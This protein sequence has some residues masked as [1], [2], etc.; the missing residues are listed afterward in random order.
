MPK[1]AYQAGTRR[2]MAHAEREQ[3]AITGHWPPAALRLACRHDDHGEPYWAFKMAKTLHKDWRRAVERSLESKS[4]ECTTTRSGVSRRVFL[5]CVP[6]ALAGNSGCAY[7]L[8]A[9]YSE[10]HH[11]TDS[12]IVWMI[13]LETTDVKGVQHAISQTFN[14][15]CGEAV[16]SGD[17]VGAMDWRIAAH[18]LWSERRCRW[19]LSSQ[20]ALDSPSI[21]QVRLMGQ[22]WEGVDAVDD[23]ARVSDDARARFEAFTNALKGSFT[24]WASSNESMKL[25]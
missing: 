1:V 2:T 20:L 14:R 24:Q 4:S 11:T 17:T 10:E 5:S 9:V 7:L 22:Y 15:F 23:Q 21:L 25:S 16:T 12:V 8:G 3:P 6:V 13:N 19:V 18:G